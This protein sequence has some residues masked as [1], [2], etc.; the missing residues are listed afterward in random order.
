[1]ERVAKQ[2]VFEKFKPTKL[3]VP[4]NK[5]KYIERFPFKFELGS[6]MVQELGSSIK[7]SIDPMT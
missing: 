6:I 5:L 3:E 2:L 4:P 7:E 1:M